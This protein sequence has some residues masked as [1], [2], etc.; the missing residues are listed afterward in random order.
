MV[1]ATTCIFS[2]FGLNGAEVEDKMPKQC[3]DRYMAGTSMSMSWAP[4]SAGTFTATPAQ[5]WKW[6]SRADEGMMFS[7]R[8]Y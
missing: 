6:E 1:C 4:Q 3:P 5:F 2:V 7:Q 8:H